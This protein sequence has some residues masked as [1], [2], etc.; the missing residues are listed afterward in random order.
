MTIPV[1]TTLAERLDA[2][3]AALSAARERL[4]AAEKDT[5]VHQA[6]EILMQCRATFDTLSKQHD[7]ETFQSG[8]MSRKQELE[9]QKQILVQQLET[10]SRKLDQLRGFMASIPGEIDQVA[11]NRSRILFQLSQLGS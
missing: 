7:D 3:S 10:E 2:A 8:E 5:A 4:D 11:Q 6:Q 1:E 9:V